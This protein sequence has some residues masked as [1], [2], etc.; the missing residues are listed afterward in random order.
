[1]TQAVYFLFGRGKHKQDAGGLGSM[2]V[3]NQRVFSER[4]QVCSD[5]LERPAS[6]V[7]VPAHMVGRGVGSWTGDDFFSRIACDLV[8][9]DINAGFDDSLHSGQTQ[10]SVN[11]SRAR[12]VKFEKNM[13]ILSKAVKMQGI[14][15]SRS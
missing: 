12:Q 8:V 10:Q 1:M 13:K 6:R 11:D 3:Q 15:H 2:M 7:V 14:L 5:Q 9:E 4:I